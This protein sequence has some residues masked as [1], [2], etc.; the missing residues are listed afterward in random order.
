M[1]S[2]KFLGGNNRVVNLFNLDGRVDQHCP[3]EEIEPD[4]LGSSQ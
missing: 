3:L 2:C 4:H 1:E